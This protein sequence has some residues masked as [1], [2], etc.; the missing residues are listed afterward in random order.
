MLAPMVELLRIETPDGRV[1]EVRVAGRPGDEVLLFHHGT[2][3]CGVPTP[4]LLDVLASRGL[5]YVSVARPG[6]AGSSRHPGRSV[7]D[8][9]ADSAAV[10][11][12]LG[13]ERCFTAGASGG[14]PHALAC[15]ALLPD[16]IRGTTTIAGVAPHDAPGL[17]FLAGMAQEN[18]DEFGVTFEGPAAL[19]AFLV[20]IAPGY[21]EVTGAEIAAA[22]GGLVSPV[23]VAALTDTFADSVAE[24]VRTALSAGIWGW[25]DDD[26]AFAAPWGFEPASIPG[27]VDVWQGEQD[28][29]VPFAHGVWLADRMPTA[30]PHLFADQGHL[31]LE[32][33]HIEAIVDTMLAGAS[34]SQ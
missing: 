11:D 22:L 24:D 25:H 4:E 9:A 31:S 3:G 21:A 12:A 15:A 29:M 33:D 18:I 1:L 13:V 14:G 20:R 28:R 6:Y 32:V 7:A 27:R 16:R 34:S 30:I 23:D 10:L 26:L 2:P 17:D 19:E 5:R 8:V